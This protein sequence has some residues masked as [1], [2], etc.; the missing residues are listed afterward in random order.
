[1]SVHRH[2]AFVLQHGRI[3][4]PAS[5]LDATGD[6][7]IEGDRIRAIGLSVGEISTNDAEVIDCDGCIIAP[8]LIDPHIHLREPGHEYKELISTGAAAAIAGGFTSVCCMPNTVPALDSAAMIAFVRGRGEA[9]GLARVFA[10]GAATLGRKGEMLAPIATMAAE[11]AVAFSDDGDCIHDAAMMS[12]VL[13]TCKAVGRAFMQ[14]AQEKTLTQGAAMNA[15]SLA[16]RMGLGGW[17]SIAEEIIVDRDVR[18]NRSI[19]ARYHV[20]HVSAGGSVDILRSARAMGQPV[21][22]E[23]SP[24]HLLLTD[25][26]CDGYNTN[27]KMNPPL[28]SAADVAALVAGVAD[29][30]IDILATDHA[31]HSPAEKAQDFASAPFG[32]IGL[33]T[34]L[35]LYIRAL[36]E[37]G[38]IEWPRLIALLTTHPAKLCGLDAQGLGALTVGGP[39]DVTVIDPSYSWTIDP[40]ATRSLSRNTPFGGWK[41]CGKATEVFVRG[42]RLLSTAVI[43]AR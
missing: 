39:A 42:Q 33:E 27:A 26:Q 35:A 37:S 4:D 28:R 18:I 2:Q 40:S 3:I 29:G 41:V 12:K 22:G 6:I 24:H 25:A 38:A 32:I 8:G 19:G 16:T 17:P 13:Q 23:A 20:Q 36:I 5:G 14:H 7:R 9:A 10:V 30:T 1:M 34:A 11:G 15:G 43:S 21:S 31:P